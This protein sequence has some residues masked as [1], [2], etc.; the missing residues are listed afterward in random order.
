MPT[1]F[2]ITGRLV[3]GDPYKAQPPS[4]DPKTKQVKV[5]PLTG[6]PVA[7]QFFVAIAI[8]KN[9]AQRLVIGGLPTWEQTKAALDAEARNA[10]PQFFPA[11]GVAPRPELPVGCTNPTFANK[12]IDG[13]GADD[14]G[15]PYSRLEGYAGC[16]VVKC[17]SMF[18]PK[19]HEWTANGWAETMHTG[20]VVKCGDY[21]TVKGDCKTNGSQQSPGVY[22][23]LAGVAFEREGEAIISSGGIDP[24]AAYGSRGGPTAAAASPST[25]AATAPSSTTAAHGEAPAPYTGY[26][27]AAPP[28][29]TGP[30]MLP[31][32]QG[33]SYEAY[34][35]KGWTDELLRANGFMQ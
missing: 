31:A 17:G 19:V 20:R 26:V 6:Q 2:Q 10:W 25:A 24:D 30:V 3:Q 22:M 7:G 4:R 1:E 18:A 21:V 23:N 33:I 5:D 12:I 15:Q 34:R 32:A 9:S 28:P 13:D 14:K 11:G 29:P 27:D 16:W 35:A 8:P